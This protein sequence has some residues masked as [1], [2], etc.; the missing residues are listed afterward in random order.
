VLGEERGKSWRN[1]RNLRGKR[2]SGGKISELFEQ[3]FET[4]KGSAGKA[5]KK[6]MKAI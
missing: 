5:Q 3:G 1:R 4:G 2:H 6:L